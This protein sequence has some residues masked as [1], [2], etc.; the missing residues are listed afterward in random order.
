VTRERQQDFEAVVAPYRS[1][2]N[3]VRFPLNQPLPTE[4]IEA[5]VRLL[6]DRTYGEPRQ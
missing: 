5:I 4:V 2:K 3:S 6:H 1:G